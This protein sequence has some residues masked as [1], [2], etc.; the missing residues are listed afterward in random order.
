MRIVSTAHPMGV[1]NELFFVPQI[2][3]LASRPRECGRFFQVGQ[4]GCCVFAPLPLPVF[5]R[6]SRPYKIIVT[7]ILTESVR[8]LLCSFLNAL[9]YPSHSASRAWPWCASSPS[10]DQ[11]RRVHCSARRF[12]VPAALARLHSA[13]TAAARRMPIASLGKQRVC[14]R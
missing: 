11:G 6:C 10:L 13:Q 4:R 12:C 8:T 3:D 14:G 7:R 1:S 9:P 5:C 2:R